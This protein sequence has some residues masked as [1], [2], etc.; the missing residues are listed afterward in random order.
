[1][2]FCGIICEFN[3]LTN[4]H[5][6]LID[7]AKEL[8]GLNVV[9]IMSGNF[10]QRGEPA[11]LDKFTRAKLCIDAGCSFCL[12]LPTAHAISPAQNFAYGAIKCLDSLGCISKIVFGSECGDISVLKE[13]AAFLA[14]PPKSFYDTIKNEL[15]QGANYNNAQTKA[16]KQFLPHLNIDSILSGPNN[17]L[18]IEYI[19]AIVL[20]RANIEVLTIKRTD[21]GFNCAEQKGKFL[22]ASAIRNLVQNGSINEVKEVVPIKTFEALKTNQQFDYDAFYKYVLLTLKLSSTKQLN[23]LFDYSEGIEFLIKKCAQ[24]ATS[25]EDFITSAQTKRYRTAKLKRLALYSVLNFTK[26]LQKQITKSP[27]TIKLLCM[28]KNEK[29]NLKYLNGGKARIVVSS[30]DYKKFDCPS[31]AL[32]LLASNIYNNFANI[33]HFNDLKIGTLFI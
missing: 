2:K 6:Y 13:I 27:P 1:M 5:L 14:T 30:K 29:N 4:G 9:A 28:K 23:T 18:A 16:L 24:S 17:I 21:N 10:T 15:K 33:P 12:E 31:L 7:K 25:I 19:K 3:P 11:I 20:Q 22:G 32:D 26:K 8:T